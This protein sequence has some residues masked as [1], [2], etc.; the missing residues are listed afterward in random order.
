MSESSTK[1][2]RIADTGRNMA[3]EPFARKIAAIGM[4]GKPHG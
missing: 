1:A 2:A 3:D 4:S